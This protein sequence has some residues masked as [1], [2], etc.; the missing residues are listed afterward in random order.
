MDVGKAVTF[1]TEDEN[2]VGKIVIGAALSFFAFLL[3]PIPIIVGYMVGITRNVKNRE[4]RPLPLWEDFGKLFMD[5]LYV[6][7]AQ[8]VYTL[9]FWLIACIGFIVT[10]G[11][12]SLGNINEDLAVGG[13]FATFGVMGCLAL[14]LW[15]ALIF[16]SPAILIQY[17]RTNDFGA[18]FRFGEV[19]EIARNNVVDILIT[20]VFVLVIS[21]VLGAIIGILNIIPCLGWI[22]TLIISAL[23]GPWISFSMGHL[24]GQIAAKVNGNGKEKYAV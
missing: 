6:I 10:I 7:V 18:C 12:G 5:G 11:F 20:M 1:V 3:I 15:V 19:I 8:F 13:L 22:L 21:F 24:Y 9:P 16:I 14:I 2:W 4:E 17:V 23:A